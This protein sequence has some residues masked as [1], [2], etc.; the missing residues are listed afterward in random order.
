MGLGAEHRPPAIF[1]IYTDKSELIFANFGICTCIIVSASHTITY[2]IPG[3][4]RTIPIFQDIPGPGNF[5]KRN[6]RLSRR[7]GNNVDLLMPK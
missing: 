5:T 6:P 1:F 4:S 2:K 3:L 7:R